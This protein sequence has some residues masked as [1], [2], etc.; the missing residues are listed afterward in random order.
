MM[1]QLRGVQQ[2]LATRGIVCRLDGSYQDGRQRIAVYP[3]G[4]RYLA[5]HTDDVDHAYIIGLKGFDD[6]S[7]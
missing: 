5:R 1:H 4:K 7:H 3:K 2:N 6:V